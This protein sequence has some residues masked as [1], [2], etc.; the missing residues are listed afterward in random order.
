VPLFF[1]RPGY[2]SMGFAGVIGWLFS[3]S[4][5]TVLLY[6]TT[7][8]HRRVPASFAS[9]S[10]NGPDRSKRRSGVSPSLTQDRLATLGSTVAAKPVANARTSFQSVYS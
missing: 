8:R 4:A 1:C 7:L 5:G 6:V 9:V 10:R 3:L 2:T